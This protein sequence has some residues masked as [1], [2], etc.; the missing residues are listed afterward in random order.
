MGTGA[1][2]FYVARPSLHGYCLAIP[3]TPLREFKAAMTLARLL[4]VHERVELQC[5]SCHL[6]YLIVT[7]KCCI[8]MYCKVL[9]CKVLHCLVQNV[10]CIDL[11]FVIATSK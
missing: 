7:V 11:S 5:V 4:T 10:C 3:S 6:F 1:D 9:Y 8:V 2:V